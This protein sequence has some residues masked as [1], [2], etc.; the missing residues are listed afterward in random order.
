MVKLPTASLGLDEVRTNQGHDS[1]RAR[2]ELAEFFQPFFAVRQ[3]TPVNCDLKAQLFQRRNKADGN[4]KVAPGIRNK[5]ADRLRGGCWQN[6]KLSLGKKIRRQSNPAIQI[7][8]L[9]KALQFE[10]I[11]FNI[12]A[13][14]TPALFSLSRTTGSCSSR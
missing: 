5:D 13:S 6:H 4:I 7:H 8:E 2:N 1:V 14:L 9:L 12:P 3:V 10:K 11:V